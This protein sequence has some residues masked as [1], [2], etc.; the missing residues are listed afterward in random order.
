MHFAKISGMQS[1][2]KL[3]KI[4]IRNLNPCRILPIIEYRKYFSDE[5]FH[6][7]RHGQIW[8][9]MKISRGKIQKARKDFSRPL[10]SL[11]EPCKGKAGLPPEGIRARLP[12]KSLHG[13]PRWPFE[14]GRNPLSD[15]SSSM[16]IEDSGYSPYI[17]GKGQGCPR[18]RFQTSARP[19]GK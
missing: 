6:Q 10:S 15:E 17:P 1:I 18:L 3:L 5:Y 13:R 16:V 19:G 11:P 4:T 7:V 9:G 14:G 12:E 2:S 8:G